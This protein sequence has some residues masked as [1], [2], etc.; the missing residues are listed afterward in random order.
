MGKILIFSKEY[1]QMSKNHMKKN[2]LNIISH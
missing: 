1:T 2:L